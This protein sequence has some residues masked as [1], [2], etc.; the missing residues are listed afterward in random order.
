MIDVSF[1]YTGYSAQ[2]VAH[3]YGASPSAGSESSGERLYATPPSASARR[4]VVVWNIT[5]SCN[6]KCLHCY[7]DS[8]AKRYSGEL[9]TEEA[10]HVIEDLAAFRIPA[11]LFSGG[12]PLVRPDL[13]DLARYAAEKGLR[14]VL[15]TNGT[16]ITASV[17]QKI[18]AAQFSYVGVSLDGMESVHDYFRGR[19]GAFKETL[20]GIRYLIAAGQKTGLRLTLTPHTIDEIDALFDLIE[21]ERI[22]RVCFYHLVPSGRGKQIF[23]VDPAKTRQG[24]DRILER[25]E[26]VRNRGGALEVLTVD[27]HAD[28]VY[29]Y[30][31]LKEKNSPRAEKVRDWLMWN[32]GGLYSSGSGIACIGFEGD[33]HP[34]QF[35]RHYVL[36]N[37][38][39]R[40]FSEIWSDETE[41]LLYKLRRRADFIHGR[42]LNCRFFD[43]CG[44]SLRV[45]SE[46]VTQDAW[47]SDPACYLTDQ[48]IGLVGQKERFAP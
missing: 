40:R 5:R 39:K 38:R 22:R 12:E 1:L 14:T 27:N 45:R 6:L 26:Q 19:R 29:I 21:Q 33:V 46:L 15:S 30:L 18:K 3:R 17:V 41:P 28:G 36:G 34:D 8:E 16:L 48:E 43:L 9:T 10:K 44:G 31:K 11:L 24:L 13:F 7:S 25:T 2:S 37:V 23:A 32:G 42:C 47:D 4:P 20:A 35:W